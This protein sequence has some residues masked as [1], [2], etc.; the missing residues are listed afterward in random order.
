MAQLIPEFEEYKGQIPEFI[1][2]LYHILEVLQCF[3]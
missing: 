3:I 2:K 1:I